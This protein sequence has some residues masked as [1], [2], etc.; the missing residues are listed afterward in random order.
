MRCACHLME[1]TPGTAHR[2]IAAALKPL[3]KS[4]V[5]SL[6]DTLRSA[7]RHK[8]LEFIKAMSCSLISWNVFPMVGAEGSAAPGLNLREAITKRNSDSGLRL[9]QA[10][11]RHLHDLAYAW[12]IRAAGQPVSARRWWQP[13]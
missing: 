4:G 5:F 1:K 3:R 13:G 11:Q 12:T 2:A 6:R 8:E 7:S 9:T 10:H